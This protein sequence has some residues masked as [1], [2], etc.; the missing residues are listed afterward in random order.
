MYNNA[1]LPDLR[2]RTIQILF[3][4]SELIVKKNLQ[5][6]ITI[7]GSSP[8]Q[9]AANS[10]ERLATIIL[11]L[12]RKRLEDKINNTDVKILKKREKFLN[13]IKLINK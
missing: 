10:T 3:H 9:N 2:A 11:V 4:K 13:I 1:L 5:E 7:L 8:I 6:K 12:D